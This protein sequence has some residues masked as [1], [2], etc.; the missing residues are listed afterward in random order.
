[1]TLDEQARTVRTREDLVALLNA[2]VADL[3]ANPDHWENGELPAYLAAMAAWISAMDGYYRNT[4]QDPSARGSWGTF[5]DILM[6]S[7]VYE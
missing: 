7:R 6:A 2:L 3:S 5:A 1:M 4:G